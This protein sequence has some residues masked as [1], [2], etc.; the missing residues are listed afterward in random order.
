MSLHVEK[1]QPS[2]EMAVLTLSGRLMMG[3]ECRQL[4]HSINELMEGGVKHV[5]VDLTHLDGIDSTGAGILVVCHSRL[6][7]A[8]GSLRI[9][10]AQGIVNETLLMIHVDRLV[11]FFPTA[12]EASQSL[13]AS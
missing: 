8:H 5:V 12:Q 4:D 2:S 9:A 13:A 1:N 6:Q 11:P 3:N 7:K 10:G